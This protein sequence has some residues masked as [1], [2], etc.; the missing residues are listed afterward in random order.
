M[1]LSGCLLPRDGQA[2]VI[3]SDNVL[4]TMYLGALQPNQRFTDETSAAAGFENVKYKS[5]PVILDGGIGGNCTASTMFF[6]NLDYLYW[7]PHPDLNFAEMGGVERD[8]VN[9]DA[10]VR[11][12]ASWA[13]SPL[14]VRSSRAASSGPNHMSTFI[15]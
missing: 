4:Y 8:P 9:Q 11:T 2:A 6:L 3:L 5:A 14:P 7:R 13:T 1:N 15:Q 10:T 12:W